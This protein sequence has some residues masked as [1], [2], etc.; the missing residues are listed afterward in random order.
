MIA[1]MRSAATTSA[2]APASNS[3]RS[4]APSMRNRGP[5]PAFTRAHRPAFGR[6]LCAVL[7]SEDDSA[8]EGS[9][10]HGQWSMR[11]L[12]QNHPIR[13]P[14]PSSAQRPLGAESPEEV[15]DVSPKRPQASHL[16]RRRLAACQHLHALPQDHDQVRL[17]RRPNV[18]ARSRPTTAGSFTFTAQHPVANRRSA[19]PSDS[20]TTPGTART[21]ASQAGRCRPQ[22]LIGSARCEPSTANSANRR[23]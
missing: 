22:T 19:S 13:P 16:F 3:S 17:N 18:R 20:S 14:Y 4:P 2:A 9:T 23:T 15:A 12:R 7:A 11:R 6:K 8:T 10:T 1:S 5:A 21:A